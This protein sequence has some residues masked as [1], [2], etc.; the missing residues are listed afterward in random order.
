MAFRFTPEDFERYVKQEKHGGQHLWHELQTKLQEW[1]GVSFAAVPY[2]ARGDRLS[3]IWLTPKETPRNKWT[4]Q[5]AFFL[6]RKLHPKQLTFGLV[7]ECAILEDLRKEGYDTDR[8]GVRLI[9]RLE[10]DPDF[11]ALV[12]QFVAD[13]DWQVYFEDE[14]VKNGTDLLERLRQV[15]GKKYWTASFQRILTAE[16][17]I[18]MGE[19][20]VDEIMA[21]YVAIQPLW[22]ALMPDADRIYL[23]DHVPAFRRE[24][25]SNVTE[26]QRVLESLIPDV[27]LRRRCLNLMADYIVAAH[28]L[29]PSTWEITL[30]KNRVRLNIGSIQ[31]FVIYSNEAYIVLDNISLTDEERQTLIS[32][33]HSPQ[34]NYV[35]VPETYDIQIPTEYIPKV[36]VLIRKAYNPLVTRA[37]RGARRTP[38][39][40]YHSPSVVAYLRK[41]LDRE[42][43]D[44]D[45]GVDKKAPE[46]SPQN[47]AFE[48]GH[49]LMTQ[50]MTHDLQYTPWQIATFYTALQTKGFVI[51]SGI[52]G[53]GKTKLAQ[54]F[55]AMLPPALPEADLLADDVI[56]IAVQPYMLKYNRVIVPKWAVRLFTPPER[57]KSVDVLV[58]FNGAEQKC[59][60]TYAD[61][62]NTN[63]IA[64]QFRGS[65]TTWFKST[66]AVSDTVILEPETDNEGNIQGFT[67]RTLQAATATH[68]TTPTIPNALFIPVRP[69]WRDSKSLLGFYNPLTG[70]YQWTPFLRF[71]QRAIRSFRDQDGLAWFVILDE[72]NLAR[73][74][75]YF[76]DLLSVLES[77]RDANGL[78]REPLRL[79]Y[80]DDA[81]GDLPSRE[82]QLPPNL[83]IVGTV[84][85][86]ETTHAFSPKVLDR[87]FTLELTDVSF[88]DYPPIS[89]DRTAAA[90][91][92]VDQ[93]RLLKDFTRQGL[94]AQIDKTAVAEAIATHPELRD[95]L[96]NLNALLHPYQLH[97]GYRV[98][99]EIATY[100]AAAEAHRL[101]YHTETVAGIDA[102]FDAAVLMKVLPKFHGSRGKL[103][104]PL[105][106]VLAWCLNPDAPDESVTAVQF[107][108]VQTEDD[109]QHRLASLPYRCPRTAERVQRMLWSLYTTG[110]AAFG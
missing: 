47:T 32:H 41:F 110:F 24:A 76:A 27:E 29:S 71:L 97:F 73:V 35:S 31:T 56:V 44:P 94:F 43:P 96:A 61:Y 57:G 37:F 11:T 20:I 18:S 4:H 39:Y 53:T 107:D 10:S 91:S 38:Y 81:E 54:A 109:L 51:L 90:L 5:A 45:Y 50:L 33:G 19:N 62:A 69:D 14:S 36:E 7:V 85:V 15:H 70:A 17:A 106:K 102:A 68:P 13:P 100:V 21:A 79:Y 25:R 87:A 40:P 80:P 77:G 78:T 12:E 8:D 88:S 92:E 34:Q 65:L 9:N 52:S 84:N 3:M 46:P 89:V 93:R 2:I 23:E 49:I 86:D 64:L 42:I 58:K 48:L 16:T 55:A 1:F 101:Y 83:Y 72:M 6:S 66:F 59:K 60:F 63:Y 74:E 75:Y 99:D 67:M 82:I 103:E 26:A 22:E 95:R 98:F 108:E 28:A 30:F 105:K 104:N